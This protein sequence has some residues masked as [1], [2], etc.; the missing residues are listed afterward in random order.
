MILVRIVFHAKWGKADEVIAGLKEG[1]GS[2]PT[3]G[4]GKVRILSDLS[5]ESHTVVVEQ[6]HESLAAWEQFR[7]NMFSNPQF[8]EGNA[9]SED[10][11]L[12]GRTEYYTIEAEF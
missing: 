12:S 9:R 10:L 2:M 11:I 5:G 6:V 3:L 8:Q 1:I 7:A 4:Q